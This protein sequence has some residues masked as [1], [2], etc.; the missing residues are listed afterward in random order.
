V[1]LDVTHHDQ[2]NR[3]IVVAILLVPI[4]PCSR[5][6]LPASLSK[7]DRF[8]LEVVSRFLRESIMMD[9]EAQTSEAVRLIRICKSWAVRACRFKQ[10]DSI[11]TTISTLGLVV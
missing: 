4:H 8:P 6:L 5:I 11:F 3:D 10:E 2:D 9:D 7:M 1:T